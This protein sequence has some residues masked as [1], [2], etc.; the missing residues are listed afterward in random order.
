MWSVRAV[1]SLFILHW[2][3]HIKNSFLKSRDKEMPLDPTLLCPQTQL[4]VLTD[5]I[6]QNCF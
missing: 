5:Y 6:A 1:L 2:Y 3:K 4:L